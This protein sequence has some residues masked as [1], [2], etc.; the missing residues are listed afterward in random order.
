LNLPGVND[1]S[2]LFSESVNQEFETLDGSPRRFTDAGGPLC[3][4][5]KNG[6]VCTGIIVLRIDNH[7]GRVITEA[8]RLSVSATSDNVSVSLG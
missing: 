1:G 4:L 6:L 5:F 3:D 8:A 7:Q 2:V